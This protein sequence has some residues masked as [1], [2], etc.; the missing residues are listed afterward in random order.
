MHW[1]INLLL[2]HWKKMLTTSKKTQE[3][4]N[5]TPAKP[6]EGKHGTNANTH[7]HT[8]THTHTQTT[9]INIQ[10]TE[11]NNYWSLISLN[12]NKVNFPTKK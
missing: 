2:L 12:I 11:I 6:K 8:H 1:K 5:S 7:T 3:V 4:S 9:T 10:I